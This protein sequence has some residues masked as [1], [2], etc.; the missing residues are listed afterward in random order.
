MYRII[1]DSKIKYSSNVLLEQWLLFLSLI[2]KTNQIL[3]LKMLQ[4]VHQNDT[5]NL[6][7]SLTFVSILPTVYRVASFF[8]DKRFSLSLT[9]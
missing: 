6:S 2:N 9:T 3:L 4:L 1:K 8:P 5:R 7:C